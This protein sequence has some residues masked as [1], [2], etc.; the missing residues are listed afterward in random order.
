MRTSL[1]AE[2][3]CLTEGHTAIWAKHSGDL[4]NREE[5]LHTHSHKH[6]PMLHVK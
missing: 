2:D 3:Q 5:V 1:F 6:T 4:L